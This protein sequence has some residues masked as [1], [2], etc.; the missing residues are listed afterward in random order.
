MP[1]G[2]ERDNR[3]GMATSASPTG[4]LAISGSRQ[5]AGAGSV[6]TPVKKAVLVIAILLLGAAGLVVWQRLTPDGRETASEKKPQV[7]TPRIQPPPQREVKPLP[8]VPDARKVVPGE[9]KAD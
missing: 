4:D 8:A 1:S 9:S 3:D 7:T 2:I 6:R 5:R